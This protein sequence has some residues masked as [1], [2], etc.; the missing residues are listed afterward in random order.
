MYQ[1]IHYYAFQ[2]TTSNSLM[3]LSIEYV[4][5][6]KKCKV[7]DKEGLYKVQTYYD[8]YYLCSQHMLSYVNEYLSWY[9]SDGHDC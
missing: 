2:T 8:T 7:C 1:Y 9:T 5:P 6:G 3:V 4:G